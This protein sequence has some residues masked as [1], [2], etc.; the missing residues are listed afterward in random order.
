[1]AFG[2]LCKNCGYQETE[3]KHDTGNGIDDVC[4]NYNPERPLT[5]E[6]RKELREDPNA[7]NPSH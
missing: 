4:D 5:K 6:E 3:H 2:V 1:M 7:D